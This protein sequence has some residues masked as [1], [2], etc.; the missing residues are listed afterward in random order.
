MTLIQ[1]YNF[2]MAAVSATGLTYL[3]ANFVGNRQYRWPVVCTMVGVLLLVTTYTLAVVVAPVTDLTLD[4]IALL[5]IVLGL[6][7]IVD[8]GRNGADWANVVATDPIKVRPTEEW[9][10]PL[11]D[12]IL[13]L[14][15]STHLV[16]TPSIIAYNLDYSRSEVSRRLSELVDAGYVDRVAKGKY[17]MT[18]S[19]E[20]YLSTGRTTTRGLFGRSASSSD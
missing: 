1:S 9:M 17:R 10:T 8:A 15:H 4:A 7:G 2:L 18:E 11:D 14:F 20:Q 19:G 6:A 3:L 16:L 13:S 12:H 5:A